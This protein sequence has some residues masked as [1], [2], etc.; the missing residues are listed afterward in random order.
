[1]T[2]YQIIC[3]PPFKRIVDL[4]FGISGGFSL[5]QK[6][7]EAYWQMKSVC[8]CRLLVF[9]KFRGWQNPSKKGESQIL[10]FRKI[11]LCQLRHFPFVQID[12]FPFL[13]F[14]TTQSSTTRSTRKTSWKACKI[15]RAK[16]IVSQED[17]HSSWKKYWEGE[18][19]QKHLGEAEA[20]CLSGQGEKERSTQGAS[21]TYTLADSTSKLCVTNF[22]LSCI[23]IAQ[24][25]VWP[26]HS[27]L[28]CWKCFMTWVIFFLH[29]ST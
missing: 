16:A 29:L 17:W 19:G 9:K 4:D 7:V 12:H 20:R 5:Q 23:K 28:R 1:M 18:D 10:L 6:S 11:K 15:M 27:C 21:F 8:P 22:K 24:K 26:T 2:P 14:M 13:I 3:G 25:K